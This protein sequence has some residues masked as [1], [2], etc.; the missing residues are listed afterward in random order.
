MRTRACLALVALAATSATLLSVP[1]PAAARSGKVRID[2]YERKIIRL[3]NRFRASHQ[4]GRLRPS[5]TLA[6]SADSHSRDMLTRDFFAHNSSDGASFAQR[7][8]H[9][10]RARNL[11]EVLA[12][13]QRGRRRPRAAVFLEMWK[14]SP[15]HR[16]LLLAGDFGRIGMAC[17]SGE[18]R[19]V[20]A[21]V[22]TAD[23]ASP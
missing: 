13:S 21:V 15:G 7:I 11:G 1:A 4:L 16:E 20:D 19:G 17:R 9:Y 14:G 23:L 2:R 18:L 5:R 10:L 6:R 12:W 22:C 8:R 3:I